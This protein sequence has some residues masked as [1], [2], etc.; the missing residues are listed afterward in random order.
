MCKASAPVFS[1]RKDVA[2]SPYDVDVT[3]GDS[4]LRIRTPRGN[5]SLTLPA[6]VTLEQGSCLPTPAGDSC[7][8]ELHYR[9][10]INVARSSDEGNASHGEDVKSLCSAGLLY[11]EENKDLS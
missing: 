5:L 8:E 11:Q 9:L 7:V 6:G 10:R 2:K 3:G 1:S 4:S